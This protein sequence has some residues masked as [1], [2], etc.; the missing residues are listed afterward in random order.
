LAALRIGRSSAASTYP[1]TAGFLGCSC[2]PKDA[3]D[4]VPAV[5][6]FSEA[7]SVEV[8]QLSAAS[9]QRSDVPFEF[10]REQE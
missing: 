2:C 7:A 6:Q 3:A 9:L 5:A 10:P 4:V 8:G 1:H